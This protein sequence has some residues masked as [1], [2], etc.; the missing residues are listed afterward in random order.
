MM[1]MRCRLPP[2]TLTP[3]FHSTARPTSFSSFSSTLIRIQLS[4]N[5]ALLV[6]CTAII[7]SRN[8]RFIVSCVTSSFQKR[9]KI[10]PF[11]SSNS[12]GEMFPC[13]SLVSSSSSSCV[14]VWRGPEAS[15]QTT[16]CEES[17]R[18]MGGQR[19][20]VV[21]HP[22]GGGVCRSPCSSVLDGFDIRPLRLDFIARVFNST[23]LV[24][25]RAAQRDVL[26]TG[27][28]R[29]IFKVASN[30]ARSCRGEEDRNTSRALRM[31]PPSL[32][33]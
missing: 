22:I 25:S 24:S 11:I 12:S 1:L 8:L 14:G 32:L 13:S 26:A 17:G 15:S 20:H 18:R 2:F 9:L 30:P 10:S 23:L 28:A 7:L 6:T 4:A 16:R 27:G 29:C 5:C 21:V 33:P 19:D 3:E 31:P